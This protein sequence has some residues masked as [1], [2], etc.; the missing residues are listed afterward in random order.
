MTFY[1]RK[2]IKILPFTDGKNVLFYLITMIM[3]F[4]TF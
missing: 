4:N 1:R 3:A 2:N